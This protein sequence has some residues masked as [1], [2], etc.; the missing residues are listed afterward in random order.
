MK[1][2]KQSELEVTLVELTGYSAVVSVPAVVKR[3]SKTSTS[4]ITNKTESLAGIF[5][6]QTQGGWTWTFS[7]AAFILG[8]LF[9]K[10]NSCCFLP[11]FL[12]VSKEVLV[13]VSHL[14]AG[15]GMRYYSRCRSSS[16]L[17][18]L[19]TIEGRLEG[20]IDIRT[21]AVSLV[22]R[23]H[24]PVVKRRLIIKDKLLFYWLTKGWLA[25]P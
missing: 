25:R 3:K 1:D 9:H 21:G 24:R 5:I 16:I 13:F 11:E 7:K 4:P 19:L 15:S 2:Q 20:E 23:M 18:I 22:I 6:P 10:C 17:G 8:M 12:L 14:S